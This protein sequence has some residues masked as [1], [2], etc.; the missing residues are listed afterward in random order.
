MKFICTTLD[1][2]SSAIG[3]VVVIDVLRAF[4]TAAYA[5]T[6]GVETITLVSAV[7]E[8]LEWKEKNPQLLLMGEMDGLPIPGFDYGNSPP[9]FDGM[10]FV[11]R[12]MIQRT[13]SCC[14]QSESDSFTGS[15]FL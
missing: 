1:I 10:D 6:A 2:C 9:Q 4:S 11:G 3:T 13:K 5:F 12:H 14:T 8:A 7:I 15:E